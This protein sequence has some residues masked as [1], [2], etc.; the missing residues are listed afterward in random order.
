MTA[1]SHH[2][3]PLERAPTVLAVLVVH[4]AAAWLPETLSGLAAQTYSRFGVV[5][6][7]NGS[8]D[9]SG[10]MLVE[11]LG[12]SRVRSMPTNAGFAGAIAR[13]LQQPGAERADFLLFLHD[14]S[15]LDPDAVTRLIEAAVGIAGVSDVGI[16]GGKVVDAADPRVLVDVGRSADRFGHPDSPLQEDE[17]DQGQFDRVL[18]VLGVHGCAM[19]VSREAW[20]RVGSFDERLDSRHADLD[21]CWRA[22]VA[23]FRV[24]MTPL[25][26]I[27]HRAASA[28]GDRGEGRLAS[29]RHEE[30]RAALAAMLKNQGPLTLLRLI[31][32]AALLSLFR[33]AYLLL[34]RRFEEA[35]EVVGAWGWNV[36]HLPGTLQRRRRVQKARRVRDRAL[37]RFTD[38]AGLRL[39][40]WFQTAERIL[41]EQHDLDDEDEGR[42]V[43][44]RLHRRTAS[45]VSAHPV[46]VASFVGIV[47]GVL[48]TRHLV[49][50]PLLAGGVLPTFPDG[51]SGLFRELV[52]ATRSTG[53]GG[54]LPASPGIGLLGIL[55]WASLGSTSLAQKVVL[56]A[57]P[58]LGAV[59]AY[60]AAVRLTGRSGP[61]TVAAGAYALSGVMLWSYSQGR[62]GGLVALAALPVLVERSEVAFGRD[63]LADGS[64]RFVSG[65]GVTLAL[66]V[67]FEPGVLLVAL[68]VVGVEVIMGS[69][70][71]RGLEL[72]GLAALVA[73]VLLFPFVPSLVAGSGHVLGSG[74]FTRDLAELAML[75]PGGGPGTWFAAA[76]L[77][78]ASVLA[79]GLV[80]AGYRARA[81]RLMAIAVAGLA[82]A[83]LSGMGYLP[84]SL[85]NAPAYL[86]L[87]AVAEALL[88]GLGLSSVITG[89]GREAFGLRQVT[90]GLMTAVLTGG[91]ALQAIATMAGGWAVGGSAQL[92]AAWAVVTGAE[93]EDFR[94]LWI[95]ADRGQPFPPPGGEPKGVID[96]GVASVRFS[97]TGPGGAGVVDIAR[98]LAGPGADRFQPAM[99]EI[100]SGSTA[101]GGAL[102]APFGVRFVVAAD[103]GVSRGVVARLDRQVDLDLVPATG[104]VI[105]R[106]A[107]A[108]PPAAALSVD[109]EDRRLILSGRLSDT[110]RLRPGPATTLSRAPGGWSGTAPASGL[111]VLSTEFDPAWE[112]EGSPDPPARAFGWATAF[113]TEAGPVRVRYEAQLPRTI[114]IV[115]LAGLWIAAV[116][117]TRKP[118]AR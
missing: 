118:V 55:S 17:I 59:L 64:W 93:S 19:L 15:V 82:L 56:A 116:W 57:A 108:L 111:T 86:S 38:S 63:E 114:E 104:L 3:G 34:G 37:R 88:V 32:L 84:G 65:L 13:V 50:P 27:R 70:R 74:V 43:T 29:S 18:E 30:D 85:S 25:A 52:S 109:E 79:F 62:I 78:V 102:L 41:E 33:L 89:L 60:R 40:R 90:T 20:T 21:L 75:T 16:V 2:T 94:V 26:R 39:P 67:A 77:P 61:S 7:D 113:D 106:N 54:S 83:W 23:G 105:F 10:A 76:F 9:G 51:P 42:R 4:D 117:V 107:A 46:I 5:A 69:A 112:L 98:P 48:A 80:G 12:A 66:A 68:V 95:A 73:A 47:V 1:S 31:P 96:A 24:L 110:I 91:I 22:R 36:A 87:A 53:F 6:V 81:A 58:A 99:Q 71:R 45:L 101:N 100:L 35:Y 92:P 8:T 72:T 14:D 11:A 28:R 103:G 49:Q 115:L 44:Q 97:V